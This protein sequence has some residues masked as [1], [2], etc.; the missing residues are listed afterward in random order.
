M[1]TSECG[2]KGGD[3]N[4]HRRKVAKGEYPRLSSPGKPCY[5][6]LVG[7]YFRQA[8][9]HN[10]GIRID[11]SLLAPNLAKRLQSCEFDKG[12]RALEKLSDHTP[13]VIRLK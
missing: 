11:H 2:W 9:E 3:R 12:P 7:H 4:T 1:L 8:F 13:I 10:R 5:G 6:W